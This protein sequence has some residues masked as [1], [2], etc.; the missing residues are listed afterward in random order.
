MIILLYTIMVSVL[1]L[2]VQ[3]EFLL[4]IYYYIACNFVSIKLYVY[5]K[6]R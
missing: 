6:M 4:M 3:F 5:N 1:G 2:S